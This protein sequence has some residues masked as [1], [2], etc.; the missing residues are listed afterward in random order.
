MSQW[1]LSHNSEVSVSSNGADA[2]ADERSS[3]LYE[4]RETGV[5]IVTLNRP[6]RMNAWGDGLATQLY[7]RLDE[8]ESDPEVRVIVLTGRGRAFCAGADMGGLDS[9][10]AAT[11]SG[12]VDVSKLVGERFPSFVTTMAKPVIAAIN[13]SCAG[14]GLVQALMCD[15]RFAAAGAKMT[16]AFARRGLTAEYGIPGSCRGSSVGPTRST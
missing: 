2:A 13:G 12:E 16:T 11:A 9:I 7:Q 5:A 14:I 10:G 3:V 1:D 6:E 4:V 8:A 15:V